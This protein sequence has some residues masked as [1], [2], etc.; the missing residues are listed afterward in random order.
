MKCK[1][2]ERKEQKELSK[3]SLDLPFIPLRRPSSLENLPTIEGDGLDP[4]ILRPYLS[5]LLTPLE[6]GEDRLISRGFPA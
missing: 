2:M 3:W 6:E 5:S 4:F 1:R